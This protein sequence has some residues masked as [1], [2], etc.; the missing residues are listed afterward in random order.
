MS[1]GAT[2]VVKSLFVTLRRGFAG[3]P[4]FH[5]RILDALG[6]KRRHQCVEK[7]N[8]QSIRGMLTK[9]PHLV[10]IETDRMRYLRE[11][12][13]YYEQLPREP[14]VLH[15]DPLHA[16]AL[17]VGGAA[18]AA[19]PALQAPPPPPP[20]PRVTPYAL[21]HLEEH[22]LARGLEGYEAAAP[23]PVVPRRYFLEQARMRRVKILTERGLFGA[24]ACKEHAEALRPK[25]F[26]RR[27]GIRD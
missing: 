7:P 8:N 13:E 18:A 6:L 12:K 9:V 24:D 15:H 25:A 4:W 5:R 2:Q 20:P 22:V 14:W 1:E 19:A 10:I 3:T 23:K 21:Q 17:R 27:I 16:A 26:R 11:M